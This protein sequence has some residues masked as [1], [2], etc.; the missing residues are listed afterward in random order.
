MHDESPWQRGCIQVYV[1]KG[2]YLDVA[3]YPGGGGGDQLYN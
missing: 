2:L 3:Q 1:A